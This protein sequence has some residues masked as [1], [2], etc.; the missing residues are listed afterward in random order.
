MINDKLFIIASSQPF[1]PRSKSHIQVLARAI[2]LQNSVLYINPPPS[3]QELLYKGR[4]TPQHTSMLRPGE[5]N[6]WVL[7]PPLIM[8]SFEG[9]QESDSFAR[10]NLMWARRLAVYIRWALKIINFREFYLICDNNPLYSMQLR[11]LLHPQTAIYHRLT[12]I[13]HGESATAIMDRVARFDGMLAGECDIVVTYSEPMTLR[14]LR[15]NLNTFNLDSP[16]EEHY[17][18]GQ[19]RA[20]RLYAAI[21]LGG[22]FDMRGE[23]PARDIPVS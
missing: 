21:A 11:R 5:K 20:D 3:R 14:M 16:G 10:S 23:L 9:D 22:S 2:C 4:N 13:A 7:D 15:Y 17:T 8:P 18:P 19:Q 12:N 1:E 6:M